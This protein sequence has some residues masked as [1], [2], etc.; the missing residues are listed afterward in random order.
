ML[1]WIIISREK[2]YLGLLC[3]IL[4]VKTPKD[5]FNNDQFTT[6]LLEG[7]ITP[8]EGIEYCE[9]D[10]KALYEVCVVLSSEINYGQEAAKKWGK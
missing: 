8:A 6:L 2:V 9:K 10:V 3:E 4:G 7:K 5:K 1:D